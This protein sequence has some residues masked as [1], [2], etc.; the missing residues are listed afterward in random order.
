[1]D[2]VH[3]VMAAAMGSDGEREKWS[4][5]EGSGGIEDGSAGMGTS[6]AG[7][8]GGGEGRNAPGEFLFFTFFLH[9]GWN[10]GAGME[11]AR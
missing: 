1:M 4:G 11:R 9:V 7:G 6:G 5:S 10:R 2:Y 8:E 3:A